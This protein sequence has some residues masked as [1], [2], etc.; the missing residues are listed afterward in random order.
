MASPALEEGSLRAHNAEPDGADANGADGE[1][2]PDRDKGDLE[3]DRDGSEGDESGAEGDDHL[4]TCPAD[5]QLILDDFSNKE[6]AEDRDSDEDATSDG[7]YS[8]DLRYDPIDFH[9]GHES[10]DSEEHESDDEPDEHS[11][12]A[13]DEPDEHSSSSDD[14]SYEHDSKRSEKHEPTTSRSHSSKPRNILSI[15]PLKRP[16]NP[17]EHDSDE[18]ESDEHDPESEPDE[19]NSERSKEHEPATSRSHSSKPPNIFQSSA[20]RQGPATRVRSTYVA[21]RFQTH[22]E[23]LRQELKSITDEHGVRLYT[24]SQIDR[25]LL[26]SGTEE[27]SQTAQHD[28]NDSTFG[29]KGFIGYFSG[30]KSGPPKFDD[31]IVLVSEMTINDSAFTKSEQRFTERQQRTVPWDFRWVHLPANNFEWVY[32]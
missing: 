26:C 19:H 7:N 15:P 13:D 2:R 18:S 27:P 4:D 22:R 21:S 23:E 16:A 29:K 9:S 1:D 30:A 14:E 32:V 24:D 6:V 20:R 17:D 8:N 11:S 28:P 12:S 25:Q 5:I 3:E 10:T 31:F